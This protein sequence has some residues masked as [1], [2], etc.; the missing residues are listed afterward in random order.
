V[1]AYAQQNVT[2]IEIGG[3][4][5]KPRQ[6]TIS[7]LKQQFAKDIQTVKFSTGTDQAQHSGTGIPLLSL[8]QAGEPKNESTPKHYDL[9]FFVII[10]AR[11][12]YRVYFSLAELLP[13][14]GNAQAWLVWDMD[15]KALPEKEAPVRLVVSSDKGHDRYIYGIARVTLVDG[16]KLA[17]RLTLGK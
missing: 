14:C 15:A 6:W 3:D 1:C 7:D 8:V 17:A 2:S 4:I 16:T 9:S 11:D 12:N 13:A 10:E 5:L